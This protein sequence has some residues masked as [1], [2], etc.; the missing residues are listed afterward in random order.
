MTAQK[1]RAFS[2]GETYSSILQLAIGETKLYLHRYLSAQHHGMARLL[3]LLAVRNVSYFSCSTTVTNSILFSTVLAR[4][5]KSY[6]FR[7][8]QKEGGT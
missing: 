6:G 7:R 1:I 2:C 5:S 3:Y 4:E 8:G